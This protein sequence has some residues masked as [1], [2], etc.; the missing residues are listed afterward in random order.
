MKDNVENASTKGQKT[1]SSNQLEKELWHSLAAY[2]NS[3]I[4]YTIKRLLPADLK[5]FQNQLDGNVANFLINSQTLYDTSTHPDDD[6]LDNVNPFA[7]D[8]KCAVNLVKGGVF[9][10][11]NICYSW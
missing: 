1:K 8:Y 6:L 11:E 9:I 10:T 2:M 5:V 7:E 4:P 3:E